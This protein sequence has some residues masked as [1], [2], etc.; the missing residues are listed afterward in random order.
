MPTKYT[1][2]VSKIMHLNILRKNCLQSFSPVEGISWEYVPVM[3]H[4]KHFP[5]CMQAD[6]SKKLKVSAA[7]VTQSTQKLENAGLI[8]KKIDPE[9]LRV[10][11]MY[12]TQK[13]IEFLKT[14]TQTF[15]RVD[16][17]MFS[18]FTDEEIRQFDS[19]LERI[20]K[21]M[22]DYKNSADDNHLLWEFKNK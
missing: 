22:S 19:L 1:G 14:G 4:I 6:I 8:E 7:A 18:G 10:K 13:G 17:I 16:G 12:I 21:N 2:T 3:E 11:R 9:N 20:N 15:D 5:G